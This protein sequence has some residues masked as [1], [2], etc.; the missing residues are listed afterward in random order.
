MGNENPK[1]S[2]DL[3]NDIKEKDIEKYNKEISRMLFDDNY[4]DNIKE[5]KGNINNKKYINS[6]LKNYAEQIKQEQLIEEM[7]R[8]KSMNREIKK[9]NYAFENNNKKQIIKKEKSANKEIIEKN[10]LDNNKLKTVENKKIIEKKEKKYFQKI[11]PKTKKRNF[12]MR[13]FTP[14][15]KIKKFKEEENKKTETPKNISS[16]A[17]NLNYKKQISSKVTNTKI[18]PGDSKIT[19]LT[20]SK[21]ASKKIKKEFKDNEINKGYI[22]EGN[23][24]RE[25]HTSK[26]EKK[27]IITKDIYDKIKSEDLKVVVNNMKESNNKYQEGLDLFEKKDYIEAKK[28]FN[29]ARTCFMN[30]NKLI[31]NNPVAYPNKFRIV[32]SL[33]INQ[34][35]RETLNLIKECNSNIMENKVEK[36]SKSQGKTTKNL[37]FNL[38]HKNSNNNINNKIKGT[39]YNTHRNI[40]SK[41]NLNFNNFKNNFK[42]NSNNNISKNNNRKIKNNIISNV[43]TNNIKKINVNLNNNKMNF[44]NEININNNREDDINN[45]EEN[46][47]EDKLSSEMMIKNIGIKFD[48]IIGM[49]EI[50]KVLQEI[51]DLPRIRYDFFTTITNP[52]KIILF[53]GPPSTGKTML[54]KAIASEYRS[55][56]FNIC[57][58][59]LTSKWFG[60][61]EKIIRLLFNLAYKKSPSIIF[62]EEIDLM[63][64][65]RNE[66]E[67]TKRLKKEFLVQLDSLK[68]NKDNKL[69]VIATTTRPMEID[70][71]LLRRFTKRIYIGPLEEND[72]FDFIKKTINKVSNSLND[73]DIK[74]IAKLS[75]GYTNSDLKELCKEAAF[76]PVRELSLEEILK[77]KDFRP[78]V[79]DDLIKSFKKIRGSL[80]KKNIEE[81]S[82]WNEKFGG[83]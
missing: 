16:P 4:N 5:E 44:K 74:E 66:N 39:N 82:K 21:D 56:F 63:L 19:I 29:E 38:L 27:E 11:E 73:D 42:I 50:K 45:I 77:I 32:I 20:P 7:N 37:N 13:L 14:S 61:S 54:A 3:N 33:K 67:E 34:K 25:K 18:F 58:S 41:N 65:K 28:C 22:S 40:T 59:S 43:A 48:D 64:D 51:I 55:T 12:L 36:S 1:F 72:R 30:L 52:Q 26:E 79:K 57:T 62:I 17:I 23:M 60:E 15:K 8:S 10:N 35:M 83:I 78:L 81:L 49:S 24:P 6:E 71:E 75:K 31:N 46:I 53:F 69:L 70:E 2:D 76:Q 9:Y 47:L 80:S 68:N